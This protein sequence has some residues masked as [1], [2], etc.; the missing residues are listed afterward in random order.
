[1]AGARPGGDPA[2]K[3]WGRPCGPHGSPANLG[4]ADALSGVERWARQRHGGL[5]GHVGRRQPQQVRG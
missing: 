5:A 2:P 3:A 4:F 1:M